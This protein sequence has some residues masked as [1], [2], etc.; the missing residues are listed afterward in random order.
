MS[1]IGYNKGYAPLLDV[2]KSCVPLCCFSAPYCKGLW[3]VHE[4]W[5]DFLYEPFAE[6][7]PMRYWRWP[8]SQEVGEEGYYLTLHCHHQND[9]CIEMGSNESHFKAS[10]II[11]VRDRVTRWCPQTTLLKTEKLK[12]NW[13]KV[14]DYVKGVTSLGN[15]QVFVTFFICFPSHP[16][17]LFFYTL[18]TCFKSVIC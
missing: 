16:H 13:T 4:S 10:W 6:L 9:S 12:Q 8:R 2:Q 7:S 14:M 15:L 17:P 11:I 18:F 3:K 5:N 1:A